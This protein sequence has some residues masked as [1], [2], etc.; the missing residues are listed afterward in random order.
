M[1]TRD[2][3]IAIIEWI[4]SNG[5]L[6]PIDKSKLDIRNRMIARKK[7]P[8]IGDGTKISQWK[9]RG[10]K[11]LDDGTVLRAFEGTLLIYDIEVIIMVHE[12][13]NK[14]V[15]IEHGTEEDFENQY[16]IRIGDYCGMN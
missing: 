3:I 15:K 1:D 12:K 8:H 9:R 5:H 6:L 13:D 16:G 2:C 7:R 4:T 10:I 11:T 14:V